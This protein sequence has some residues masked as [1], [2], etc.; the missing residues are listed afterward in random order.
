[1][2]KKLIDVL[3]K[4]CLDF[5]KNNMPLMA[6]PLITL[7]GELENGAKGGKNPGEISDEAVIAKIQSTVHNL[8]ITIGHAT[9]N[10]R[11]EALPQLETEL[12]LLTAY[13]PAQLSLEVLALAI[14]QV[15]DEFKLSSSKGLGVVMKELKARYPGQYDGE[16]AKKLAVLTLGG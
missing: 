4:D 10:N 15:V 14:S 13:L 7:I 12:K 2:T 3:R 11:K 5:R 1:M 6:S 8:K 16:T 9:E